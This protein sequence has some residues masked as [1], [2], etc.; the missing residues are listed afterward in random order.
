MRQRRVIKQITKGESEEKYVVETQSFQSFYVKCQMI[1]EKYEGALSVSVKRDRLIGK[2]I[3]TG[4]RARIGW[5]KERRNSN[6]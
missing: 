2:E 4:L 1:R 3:N 6:N 5:L